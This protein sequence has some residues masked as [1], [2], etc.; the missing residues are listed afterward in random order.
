MLMNAL[1]VVDGIVLNI[2]NQWMQCKEARKILWQLY[3][4]EG[5]AKY[6]IDNCEVHTR[7]SLIY[8]SRTDP[9]INIHAG[10]RRI[11]FNDGG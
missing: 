4:S 7:R 8:M 11:V 6:F 3:R 9:S 5:D 1:E 10:T 2:H